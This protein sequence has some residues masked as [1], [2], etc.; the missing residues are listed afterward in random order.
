MK[1]NYFYLGAILD[2]SGSMAS[3]GKIE[4]ARNG[5]NEL[6]K[7]KKTQDHEFDVFVT[8]FDDKIDL[9]YEGTVNNCPKLT[10]ENFVPRGMTSL[11]DAIGITV[12]KI[13]KILADKKEDERPEKVIITVITDGLE[14]NSKEFNNQ[15]LKEI[16]DEQKKK[17]NWEFIFMGTSEESITEAQNIG[18]VHT[19]Q[20]DNSKKGVICAYA[21]YSK[22]IDVLTN[23]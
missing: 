15:R 10:E 13:G 14:N 4:E 6:I 11:Y 17:Y 12:N 21:S 2:R 1:S 16:I 9:L 22:S 7:D 20:Y 5:F 3:D 18:I 23:S 8:I 19:M